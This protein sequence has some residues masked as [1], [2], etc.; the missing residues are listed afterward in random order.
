MNH[1]NHH[2][3]YPCHPTYHPG[4]MGVFGGIINLTT[5]TLQGAA[6]ITRTVV[7]GSVW[8]SCHADHHYDHH[9]DCCHTV[10]HCYHV[11]CEPKCFKCSSCCCC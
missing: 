10:H 6:H 7:E 5:A 2:K 4:L 3:H 11:E 9:S 1:H 8:H